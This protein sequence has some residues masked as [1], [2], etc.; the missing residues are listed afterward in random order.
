MKYRNSNTPSPGAVC[1]P[2]LVK[3]SKPSLMTGFHG[4]ICKSCDSQ[5][6]PSYWSGAFFIIFLT[7]T[8]IFCKKKHTGKLGLIEHQ[9]ESVTHQYFMSAY[10]GHLHPLPKESSS[11]PLSFPMFQSRWYALA[12]PLVS[13]EL[14]GASAVTDISGRLNLLVFPSQLRRW[15]GLSKARCIP[16]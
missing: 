15:K 2:G 6:N 1:M 10:W 13:S 5:K 12:V 8:R 4:F 11:S 16:R 14:C 7:I 9:P 3:G